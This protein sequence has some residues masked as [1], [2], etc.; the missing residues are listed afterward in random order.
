MQALRVPRNA[1]VGA[2][3]GVGFTAL[4]FLVFVVLP[5]TTR[6]PLWYVGL[7]FVLALS[8]AGLVAFVLTLARAVRLSRTL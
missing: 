7:G 1:A 5:G 3:V 2:A 4:V 6:S 8:V